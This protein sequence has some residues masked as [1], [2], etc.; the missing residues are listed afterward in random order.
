MPA[1]DEPGWDRALYRYAAVSQVQSL[2]LGGLSLAEAV[3]RASEQAFP[4]PS[5]GARRAPRSSL[6]RWYA[7]YKKDGL[8]GAVGDWK[9]DKLDRPLRPEQAILGL[10]KKP[11]AVCELPPR[12][13][14]RA[15]GGCF[16]SQAGTGCRA[17][18]A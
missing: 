17:R 1:H 10:R 9:Y 15:T 18:P 13:L 14:L 5:G 2:V 11:G 4:G 7:D 6:Y 16:Q 3:H 8:V 12:H